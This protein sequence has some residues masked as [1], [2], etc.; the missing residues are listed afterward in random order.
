M[1]RAVVYITCTAL[2][3]CLQHSGKLWKTIGCPRQSIMCYHKK[4]TVCCILYKGWSESSRPDLV[5]FRI[6]LKYYLLLIVARLGTQHAQY[7]FWAINILCTLPVVS[8]LHM[9]WKKVELHGV[10]K[11]QFWLI[12]SFHCML[13]FSDTESKWCIHVSSWIMSCEINFC[14]VTSVSFN[15]FIGNLC[16]VLALAFSTVDAIRQTLCSYTE[17]HKIF[18]R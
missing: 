18:I 4:L 11:W 9:T 3:T 8:C 12:H 17:M 14:W 2:N 6:K 1:I 10:M 5:L 13:C 7:D 16:A 15:N